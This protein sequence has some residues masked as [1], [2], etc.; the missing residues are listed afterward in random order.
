M[1]R[2][3]RR[4]TH[5]PRNELRLALRII[6]AVA[7]RRAHLS[8]LG[9]R[10]RRARRQFPRDRRLVSRAADREPG[11]QLSVARRRSIRTRRPAGSSLPIAPLFDTITATVV[12]AAPRPRC[13]HRQQ[14]SASPPSCRRC[15]ARCRHRRLGAR[16][17]RLRLAAPALL[18]AATAG[19]PARAFLDRTM[20][21][22]VDHHA[23]EALLALTTLLAI[24]RA[25]EKTAEPSAASRLALA[26]SCGSRWPSLGSAICWPGQRRLSR[27]DL[28]VWLVL[29]VFARARPDARSHS[30]PGSPVWRRSSR[31]LLVGL[32]QDPRD[33][34][35]WQP[36]RGPRWAWRAGVDRRT[37][38][39][40]IRRRAMRAAVCVRVVC[41]RR[42]RCER[43]AG[44]DGG[45]AGQPS[46][47]SQLLIDVGRLAPDPARM[48]VLEARPLFLY[49]GEWNWLQPWQFFRT[50][51]YIGA[52]RAGP[53]RH[54]ALAR[55]RADDFLSGCLPSRPSCATIGQNRFGYYLVTACALLGGWLAHRILEMRRCAP[56]GVRSRRDARL[57]QSAGVVVVA[58]MFAPNLAP[59]LLFL[60]RTGM[61]TAYWQEA[62]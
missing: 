52:R 37:D 18:A 9:R 32:F 47:V 8:C 41:A 57:R 4:L 27:G 59:R 53:A 14:S 20:L 23:L 21:G 49:P 25:M 51:F 30:Q 42:A 12:V 34:S 36:D 11:P 45:R 31:W 5:A 24:V 54:P 1:L 61:F 56:S 10:V 3:A 40:A 55:R 48:G 29:V 2:S 43:C 58:A 44:R 62:L 35:L 39:A 7:V 50:G 26:A 60:P 16:P 15:S 28:G 13:R 17:A 22:F 19:D 6:A 38:D 33:A 46:L